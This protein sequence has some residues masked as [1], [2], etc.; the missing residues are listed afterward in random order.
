MGLTLTWVM[1][2]KMC[3]KLQNCKKCW[4]IWGNMDL[5][6]KIKTSLDFNYVEPCFDFDKNVKPVSHFILKTSIL[7]LFGCVV[8]IILD[9]NPIYG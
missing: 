1:T 5:W 2:S 9:I 4:F 7:T 6:K 3:D 8:K